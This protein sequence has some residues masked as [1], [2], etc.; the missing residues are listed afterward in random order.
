MQKI[1]KRKDG[2][3]MLQLP[4]EGG[5]YRCI[6][7]KTKTEVREKARGYEQAVA[8][9]D[10][11]KPSSV[12]FGEIAAVWLATYPTG[13]SES[14]RREYHYTLKN[15]LNPE[16]SSIRVQNIGRADIQEFINGKAE[17]YS[18]KTVKKIY[19]LLKQVLDMAVVDGILRANPCAYVKTPK[20]VTKER[21]PL[22]AE[23]AKSLLALTADTPEIE[24]LLLTGL[25]VFELI[26][27]LWD[28]VDLENK[29]ITVKRQLSRDRKGFSPPKHGKERTVP[30]SDD[31]V[32]IL[33]KQKST[34][35]YVF[36]NGNDRISYKR[37]NRL[38]KVYGAQ[39]GRD[40]LSAHVL[41]HTYASLLL[42]AGVNPKTI[43][44]NLGH[45]SADFTLREYT[46][47]FTS[48]DESTRKALDD[49]FSF[50]NMS[51]NM[52][53]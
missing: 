4:K 6:Y 34:C 9:G 19:T 49:V 39:I 23:E 44:N 36:H 10:Y 7:G 50:K 42:E 41:R 28:A 32:K 2:R 12:T 37:L 40:D 15:H 16:F 21:L 29:T 1:T 11:I 20:V 27:L 26:G 18:T 47:A 35:S 38:L 8:A 45:H 17:Q 3:Y 52:S 51:K 5:G 33:E 46:H 24:F 22:S 30:L 31:A 43:Q 48:G 53:K 13:L 25:R 14:T